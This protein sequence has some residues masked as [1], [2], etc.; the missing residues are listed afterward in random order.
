MSGLDPISFAGVLDNIEPSN[1]GRFDAEDMLD[2]LEGECETIP[3]LEV[4]DGAPDV[5]TADLLATVRDV[6]RGVSDRTHNEYLRLITQCAEFLTRK[7]I[8]KPGEFFSDRPHQYA[9]HFIVVWIMNECDELDLNGRNRLSTEVRATYGTAQKMRTSMTYAFGRIHA[10]GRCTGSATATGA[11]WGIP[12]YPSGIER[13]RTGEEDGL[14]AIKWGGLHARQLLQLA[15]T[16]AFSC[17]LRVDEVLKIQSQDITQ[18]ENDRLRLT[19]TVPKDEPVRAHQACCAAQAGPTRWPTS[20][21]LGSGDRISEN[22]QPMTAE[23][24]LE[25]FR[26]NLIDIGIDPVAYG[27]HS[28]RRGGCQ[29]LATDLRWP[30]RWICEW[31]GWSTEFMHLTIVKYLI[32]WN[33]DP[34]QKREE[35]FNFNQAPALKCF[36][37]GRSCCC[38]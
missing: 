12:L 19:L 32:S 5:T 37:C 30:L 31:G 18:L 4:D 9:P 35:F 14:P 24:F 7:N 20:A 26:N 6:S 17:L 27:T 2:D 33:D 15:Y 11:W 36:A 1:E 34:S 29:W 16:L 28:F 10:S 8:A 25:M 38:S 13:L 3:A 22:N 21:P 23:Y